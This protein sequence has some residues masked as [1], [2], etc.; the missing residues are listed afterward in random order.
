MKKVSIKDILFLNESSNLQTF[1]DRDFGVVYTLPD[2]RKACLPLKHKE[3]VYFMGGEGYKDVVE[4][5]E[6]QEDIDAYYG[7]VEK[8]AQAVAEILKANVES[9]NSQQGSI[10]LKIEGG[11]AL[12]LSNEWVNH[13]LGLI[14]INQMVRVG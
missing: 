5:S 3:V 7:A 11:R 6:L 8:R 14:G 12:H 10:D 13:I 2:G 9:V 1:L 4:K